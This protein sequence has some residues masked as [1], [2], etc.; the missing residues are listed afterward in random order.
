MDAG[1]VVSRIRTLVVKKVV[2]RK[3]EKQPCYFNSG[4]GN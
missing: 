2:W 3:K 1:E 4:L